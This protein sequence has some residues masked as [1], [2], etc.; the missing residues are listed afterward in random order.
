M[1]KSV[2][3]RTA[4]FSSSIVPSKSGS[5]S[6]PVQASDPVLLYLRKLV[7]DGVIDLD[8]VKAAD[9]RICGRIAAAARFAEASPW[10]EAAEALAGVFAEAAR[11]L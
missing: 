4:A 3:K 8:A 7:D 2:A 6:V 10:P 9:E 1:G 11:R 5:S